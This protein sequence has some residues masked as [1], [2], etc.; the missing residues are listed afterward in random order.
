[1]ARALLDKEIFSTVLIGVVAA[2]NCRPLVYDEGIGDT[3]E[4]FIPGHFLTGHKLAKVHSGLEPTER[5]L[6]RI[7]E[8]Q[9]LLSILEE[10]VEGMLIT[11]TYL[12]TSAW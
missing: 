11:I 12:S 1:M 4:D 5:S 9:D 3:E 6:T 2:F 10:M 8:Q 7:L